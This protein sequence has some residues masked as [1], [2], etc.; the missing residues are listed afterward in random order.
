MKCR[1]CFM[2]KSKKI[3]S[4]GFAQR[5]VKVNGNGK[6]IPNMFCLPSEDGALCAQKQTGS[7]K[8][9]LHG[10]MAENLP[11]IS[12]H[13]KSY[14]CSVIFFF[15]LWKMNEFHLLYLLYR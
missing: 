8:S 3:S 11:S 15:F 14:S 13:L 5:V 4:A 7:H 1:A 10:N 9:C 12:S 2:G 6:T